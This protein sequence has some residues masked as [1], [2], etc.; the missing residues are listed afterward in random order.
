MPTAKMLIRQQ[1][2]N[3]VYSLGQQTELEEQ[4]HSSDL[5]RL[6]PASSLCSQ[7]QFMAELQQTC[8]NQTIKN[9][10]AVL[11]F[12]LDRFQIIRSSLGHRISEELLVEFTARISNVF[13]HQTTVIAH[14]QSDEF[15]VLLHDIQSIEDVVQFARQVHERLRIPFNISG[16]E[17]FLTASI[18]I[19]TSALSAR[20]PSILLNDAELAVCHAK[21][22]CGNSLEI[23]NTALRE[24]SMEQLRLENDLRLGII[25]QEFF[26]EYQPI[27]VLE[28]QK[29]AGFEAL[30]RWQ[31]PRRGLVSPGEFIPI[32]E[33]TGSIIPLGWWVLQ[34]A[35]QQLKNWQDRFPEYHDLTINVNVSGQQFSQLNFIQ[36][37]DQILQTTGL[38]GCNLKL[39]IT[40]SVLMEN[41]DFAAHV[42]DQLKLRGIRLCID[43]FGTGY[44]SLSYLQR[45]EVNTLKIDRSFIARMGTDSKSVG[46]LQIILML[47]R[48]LN[49][50]VVAEGIEISEQY[51]QLRALQCQQGQGY[52]FSGP[53]NANAA[54][55]RLASPRS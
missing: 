21:Q 36:Q 24:R 10:F 14:L 42:L 1:P 8:Q 26:L 46:I 39:E 23:F 44:S 6:N 43:D 38:A 13:L 4:R 30:L 27:L 29:L 2:E 5:N 40:E 3:Q 31:H 34:E 47:A 25:R 48:Q 50:D 55:Q 54:E 52:L 19:T 49:M 37:I 7:F 41:A 16:S 20:T 17:I 32:A 9:Y 12:D 15:A 22:S 45:F 53:L 18:G 28:D 35:C 33:E 51:W 11:L